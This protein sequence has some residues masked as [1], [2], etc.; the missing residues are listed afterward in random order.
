MSVSCGNDIGS[1]LVN[2]GMNHKAS[3]IDGNL[4]TTLGNVAFIIDKYQIGSLDSGEMLG[5]WVHPKVILQNRVLRELA[6]TMHQD[7]KYFIPL[8]EMWPDT[9]SPYPSLPK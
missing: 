9:P 1:S 3:L 4:G 7:P 5:E 6:Y 2:L 8:I